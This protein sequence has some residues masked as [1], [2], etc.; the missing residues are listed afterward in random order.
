[1]N[2][3]RD[4]SWY[5]NLL[6]QSTSSGRRLRRAVY[7]SIFL[8]IA[9][10]AA[11]LFVVMF[12][13]PPEPIEAYQVQLIPDDRD[14]DAEPVEDAVEVP[15]PPPPPPPPPEPEIQEPEPKPEP[16]VQEMVEL[17]P[18]FESL[19][20]NVLFIIDKWD[21]RAS[22]QYKIDEVVAAMKENPDT[23]VRV[24]GYADKDTGTAARNKFLS[25]KRAE[26]VGQAIQNAGIAKDRII[27]E[28]FGDTVNPFDTPEEN[29]VAVC[30]VK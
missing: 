4:T 7:A 30:L 19:T 20:R 23:K 15:P 9:V 5:Y 28:Y 6:W 26:V 27:T 22:E 2:I 14:V 18:A 29:R 10:L 13:E 16:V 21:I 8:H 17:V 12:H 11:L 24:S 25:Q 1:M 3:G